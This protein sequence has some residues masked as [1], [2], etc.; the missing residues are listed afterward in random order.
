MNS[1][2]LSV[3]AGISSARDKI[4]WVVKSIEE[5]YEAVGT[6]WVVNNHS[7]YLELSQRLSSETKNVLRFMAR[8]A[9]IPTGLLTHY[10]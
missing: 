6:A 7:F 5:I 1:V 10:L 9:N 8:R 2:G 4:S 3:V